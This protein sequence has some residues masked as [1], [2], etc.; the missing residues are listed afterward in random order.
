MWASS[1][2]MTAASQRLETTASTDL[3]RLDAART[4]AHTGESAQ[5]ACADKQ[6]CY[7]ADMQRWYQVM[8]LCAKR[9]ADDI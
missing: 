3:L 5:Y 1:N 2:Q 8:Q 4:A 7:N 6:L 9:V